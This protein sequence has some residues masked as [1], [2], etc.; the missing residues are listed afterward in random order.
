MRSVL[1]AGDSVPEPAA[2]LGPVARRPGDYRPLIALLGAV[3]LLTMGGAFARRRTRRGLARE[4]PTNLPAVAPL[5]RWIAAGE[6]RAVAATLRTLALAAWIIA[7]AGPEL[8]S[9]TTEMTREGIAI[10]LAVDVS[11]SMMAEDFEPQN[12]LDVAKERSAAFVRGR[13]SDRIA[14]VTF[15]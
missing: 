4:A 5:A 2:S 7:A 13:K 6:P 10:V 9:S 15:A 8:G 14:L 12:L 11:C 3:L 1:P